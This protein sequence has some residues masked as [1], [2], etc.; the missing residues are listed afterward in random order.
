MTQPT[1]AEHYKTHEGRV[2]DKWSLYM[3]EYERLF[4]PYRSKPIHL[5]EIGVQN[6]GSLE[7]WAKYFTQAQQ[8]VGCDINPACAQLSYTNSKINVVVGDVNQDDTL[9]QV[10]KHA[11]QYD[12]VIDDGSHTVVVKCF[13]PPN[14]EYSSSSFLPHSAVGHRYACAA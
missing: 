10:F 11:E 6:G 1:L 13:W 5:L 7:I 9:A 3:E 14:F 2:S 12:I 8:I 4:A